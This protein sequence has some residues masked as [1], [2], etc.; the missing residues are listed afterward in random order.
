MWFTGEV[1]HSPVE[2]QA[3]LDS[4]SS[5]TSSS[6][7]MIWQNSLC[8]KVQYTVEAAMTLLLDESDILKSTLP[9]MN[10][11]IKNTLGMISYSHYFVGYKT[12][13]CLL[14]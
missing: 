11:N 6:A 12:N 9:S 3:T 5:L 14:N 8:L 7:R 10:R 2:K 1:V 4:S 13:P